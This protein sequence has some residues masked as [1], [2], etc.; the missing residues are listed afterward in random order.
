MKHN[1]NSFIT[2]TWMLGAF[3]FSCSSNSGQKQET[4]ENDRVSRDT[5]HLEFT[6]EEAPEWTDLFYRTPA[7]QGWFGA[8]GIFSLPVNGVDTAGAA[9]STLLVFS[10]SMIGKIK[11]GELQPGWKMANNTVAYL[12]GSDPD[13]ERIRFYWNPDA[14]DNRGSLFIPNTPS[15]QEGDYYWLGDGF[16]NTARN[17]ATYIF[18]YRMRNLSED[19]WSF[20]NMGNVL[21]AIPEGSKPPFK[22]QRQ[23]ET[24]FHFNA[25]SAD[26]QGSFGAGILVN[27]KDA[28]VPDPDGYVYVYGVR[29]KANNLLVAR[30]LPEEFEEFGAW[31]FWDGAGWNADM[32]QA[33]PSADRVSNELS[34]SPL[35]D[36]RYALVFQ[37][38]GM[39]SRVGLRLGLSPQGPFG[40]MITI[41][42]C[43]ENQQENIFVY[44]AK[45]HPALSRPGEL[46]VSYNVNAFDFA[47]EIK[48][49]P[50]LY[51]PRFIRVKLNN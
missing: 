20:S 10:D 5:T 46:L 43:T 33:A 30:V 41:W 13:E 32:Q 15:A 11:D 42:E 50:N 17:N 44:N 14:E 22:E 26:E 1:A 21:I 49:D 7:T 45:A 23:I 35:P 37:E 12:R 3:L 18:A 24:P 2:A 47:N 39:G 28:G 31:R 6:V 34:V 36:G 40:P 27:T 16:V 9:D 19:A 8:D 4:A 48:K 38:A 51:R 29:G 25:E